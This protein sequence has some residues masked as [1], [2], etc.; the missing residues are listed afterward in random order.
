MQTVEIDFHYYL[1]EDAVRV[2][3]SIINYARLHGEHVECRFITGKGKIQRE[4][5]A[6]LSDTYELRP[7]VPMSNGGMILVEIY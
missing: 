7:V 4:L 2:T 3:E 1:V 5:M 6:L